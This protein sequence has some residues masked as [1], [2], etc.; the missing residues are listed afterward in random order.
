[1]Q[2]HDVLPQSTKEDDDLLV[3]HLEEMERQ[4]GAGL[5]FTLNQR[6]D[7]RRFG[8]PHRIYQA[9]LR[10]EDWAL[11]LARP[12]LGLDIANALR[13]AV[14][15]HLLN[16]SDLGDSDVI[17]VNFGSHQFTTAFQSHRMT[18]GEWRR[19][20]AATQASKPSCN[21]WLNDSIPMKSF[22]STT[23]ST[24]KLQRSKILAVVDSDYKLGLKRNE[25]IL[26]EK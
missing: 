16:E 15:G 8:L 25:T 19:G 24:Y 20:D 4:W 13:R 6:D 26:K 18:V 12:H 7:Q 23:P 14:D 1:M 5:K 9:N 10:Q 22:K 3:R 17:L 21:A 11:G 2:E